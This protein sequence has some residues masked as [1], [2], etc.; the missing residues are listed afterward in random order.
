M[1]GRATPLG[2]LSP[3]Q[4][5]PPAFQPHRPTGVGKEREGRAEGKHSQN[6]LK[7]KHRPWQRVRGKFSARVPGFPPA[8]PA[9]PGEPPD[10]AP[11]RLPGRVRPRVR[12]SVCLAIPH[13]PCRGP[14]GICGS[15]PGAGSGFPQPAESRPQ[16]VSPAPAEPGPGRLLGL[17]GPRTSRPGRGLQGHLWSAS[18]HGCNS[19][20]AGVRP[21]SLGNQPAECVRRALGLPDCGPARLSKLWRTLAGSERLL[22]ASRR[23]SKVLS[24]VPRE[25][26]VGCRGAFG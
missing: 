20:P 14:R 19:K 5:P 21:V 23:G 16:R 9:A 22:P 6:I 18:P 4:S 10:P 11:R 25:G 24:Q 13:P 7:R 1:G 15:E 26:L 12:P 3:P 2:C 17:A 8:P